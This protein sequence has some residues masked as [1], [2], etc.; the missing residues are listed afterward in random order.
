MEIKVD[1]ASVEKLIKGQIKLAAAEALSK[2][3]SGGACG[4]ARRRHKHQ[5]LSDIEGLSDG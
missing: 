4:W 1:N 2:E 5:R 3:D